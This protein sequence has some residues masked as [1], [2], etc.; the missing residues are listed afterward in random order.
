VSNGIDTENAAEMAFGDE[1]LALL[2]FEL[3]PTSK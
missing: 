1:K 3:A 2:G